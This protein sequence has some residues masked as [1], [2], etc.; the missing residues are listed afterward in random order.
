[1]SVEVLI[2]QERNTIRLWIH[3][4]NI[5]QWITLESS[6]SR[7]QRPKLTWRRLTTRSLKFILEHSSSRWLITI[8]LVEPSVRLRT[9]T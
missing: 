8:S 4:E 5:S 3:T 2:T 9:L 6:S 1:M 7:L